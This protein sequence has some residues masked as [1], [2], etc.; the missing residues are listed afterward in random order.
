MSHLIDI[1]ISENDSN[2][3]PASRFYQK[4][5]VKIL[6]GEAI[7]KSYFYTMSSMSSIFRLQV[8][9]SYNINTQELCDIGHK[10]PRLENYYYVYLSSGRKER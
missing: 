9:F 10:V 3:V 7:C 6:E 1:T 4:E 8:C 5:D 2:I